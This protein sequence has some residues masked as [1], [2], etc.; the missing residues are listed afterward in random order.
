MTWAPAKPRRSHDRAVRRIAVLLAVVPGVALAQPAPNDSVTAIHD[1]AVA[2]ATAGWATK[3]PVQLNAAVAEFKRAIALDDQPKFE[4]NL[5]VALEG[6]GELARA[7]ARLSRCAPRLAAIDPELARPR[8]AKLAELEAA[9]VTTHAALRLAVSD[10]PAT[11]TIS[12]FP[13]DEIMT[14]PTTVWLAPGSPTLIVRFPGRRAPSSQVVAITA[15]EVGTKQALQIETPREAPLEPVVEPPPDEV[16][17]DRGPV[18]EPPRARPRSRRAATIERRAAVAPAPRDRDRRAR[19][20]RGGGDRVRRRAAGGVAVG[21]RSERSARRRGRDRRRADRCRRARRR[22]PRRRCR[23]ARARA[24]RCR[25]P[26]ADDRAPRQRCARV[27]VVIAAADRRQ[28]VHPVTAAAAASPRA[29]TRR[30]ARAIGPGTSSC[31][32]CPASV[33]VTSAA[34]SSRSR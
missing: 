10:G 19:A 28:P 13:D 14:L 25:S 2:L 23:H 7:H 21:A 6:L 9:L 3:D 29:T 30:I 4:C 20:I 12:S 31:R 16:Q 15:A 33:R 11:A 27:V 32:K 5:A 26:R 8:L 34:G 22:D 24:D 18:V 1:R 17:P